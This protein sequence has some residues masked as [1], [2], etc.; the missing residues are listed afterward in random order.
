[1]YRQAYR[2]VDVDDFSSQDNALNAPLHFH[3][4]K[5]R[6]FCFRIHGFLREDPFLLQIYFHIGIRLLR[7]TEYTFGIMV[8]LAD[9]VLALKE[10][11]KKTIQR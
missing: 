5:G 3:S 4:C 10:S 6:P 2:S 1:M 7:Q 9:N 8:T 11:M